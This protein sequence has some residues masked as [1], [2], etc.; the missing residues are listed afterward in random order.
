[1]FEQKSNFP[2]VY[3]SI[4]TDLSSLPQQSISEFLMALFSAIFK[5]AGM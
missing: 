1:M 5:D 3:I 4:P 2:G